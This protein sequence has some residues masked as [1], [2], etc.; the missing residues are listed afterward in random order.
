[1]QGSP[2]LWPLPESLV[3][4][5]TCAGLEMPIAQKRVVG[6]GAARSKTSGQKRLKCSKSLPLDLAN[7]FVDENEQENHE[8][9]TERFKSL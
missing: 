6:H 1:M 7:E 5:V 2:G 9:L 4:F 8:N 3:L